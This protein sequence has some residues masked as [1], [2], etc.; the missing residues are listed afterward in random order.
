MRVFLDSIPGI[1]FILRQYYLKTNERTATADSD[2]VFNGDVPAD[3]IDALPGVTITAKG[4][5]AKEINLPSGGR[6]VV[7]E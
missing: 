4:G 6:L 5:E 3:A 7:V 2:V 1:A